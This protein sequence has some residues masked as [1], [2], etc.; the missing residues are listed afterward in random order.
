MLTFVERK[1]D[2]VGGVDGLNNA[3]GVAVS[4]DNLTVYI[5]GFAD[6]A[7][8]VFRVRFCGDGVVDPREQCDDGNKTN[9]DCCS[10]TCTVEAAGSVCTDDSNHCTDDR[11]NANATCMH[12]NRAGSCDDGAFCTVGDTCQAGVCTGAAR[13]CSGAAADQCHDGVCDE[14]TD[15]CVSQPK[16]D[17]TACQRRQQLHAARHLPGRRLHRRRSR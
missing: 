7:V 2:G 8:A 4:P 17:G 9:G 1:H 3:A 6:D 15:A 16:T 14:N 13:N 10:S 12:S 11:C 5:T